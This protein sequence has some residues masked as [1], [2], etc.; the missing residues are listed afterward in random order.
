MTVAGYHRSLSQKISRRDPV[1]RTV[2]PSS[3]ALASS[4]FRF[5]RFAFVS[6]LRSRV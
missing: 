3:A 6:L 2:W 4:R 5:R 1:D